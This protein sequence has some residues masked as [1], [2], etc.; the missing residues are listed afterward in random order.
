MSFRCINGFAFGDSTYPGGAQVEDDDPIL[1]THRDHFAQV[2]IPAGSGVTETAVVDPDAE[3]NT[4]A[5]LAAEESHNAEVIAWLAAEE[6]HNAAVSAAAAAEAEAAASAQSSGD[7]QSPAA[8]R[9]AA[10]AAKSGN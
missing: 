10:R 4:L 9:R 6:E 3:S 7:A 1:E 8:A 5:W 2:H